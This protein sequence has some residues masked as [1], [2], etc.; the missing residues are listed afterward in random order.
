MT[1]ALCRHP[2]M[3]VRTADLALADLLSDRGETASV[4]REL[5]HSRALRS[6]ARRSD[7]TRLLDCRWTRPHGVVVSTPAFHAGSGSPAP[8]G[9]PPAAPEP[10]RRPTPAARPRPPPSPP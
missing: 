1:G 4:P 2:P 6:F 8:P 7:G 5:R 10:L 9:G 3:A